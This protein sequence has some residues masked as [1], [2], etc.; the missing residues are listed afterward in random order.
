M[1]QVVNEHIYI[2]A[3]LAVAA[4]QADAKAMATTTTRAVNIGT[5]P[6]AFLAGAMATKR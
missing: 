1:A 4:R 6:V 3:L 5:L 2:Y